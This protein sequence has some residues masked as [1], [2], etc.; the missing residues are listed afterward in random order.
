MIGCGVSF[1]YAV[2][3][4]VWCMGL[5]EVEVVVAVG[6]VVSGV[7]LSMAYGYEF[8]LGPE[9]LLGIGLILAIFIY[10]LIHVFGLAGYATEMYMEPDGH[11]DSK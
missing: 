3:V 8:G 9:R 6:S 4:L 11:Q 10:L 5:K 2:R 1:L 7:A